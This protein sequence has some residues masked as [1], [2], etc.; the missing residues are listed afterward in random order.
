MKKYEIIKKNQEFTNILNYRHS[1]KNQYYS[2]YYKESPTSQ[3]HYGISIPT[4]T[5]KA[6]VRNKL[7]RQ[8]KNIIDNNKKYI[9]TPYDYVI[10]VR[11]SILDLNYQEMEQA[12][13]SL[14]KKIG[15]NK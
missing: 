13:I 11:K 6:V 4:K 12:L 2:L 8:I 15:E 5:G 7:K 9:Q 3:N 1:K 10:I 14:M